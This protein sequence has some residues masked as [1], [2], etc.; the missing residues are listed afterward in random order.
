MADGFDFG[1]RFGQTPLDPGSLE[2]LGTRGGLPVQNL[3]PQPIPAMIGDLSSLI[4]G[5][6]E[7]N[8]LTGQSKKEIEVQTKEVSKSRSQQIQETLGFDPELAKELAESVTNIDALKKQEDGIKQLEDIFR[9][10]AEQPLQTDLSALASLVDAWTGSNF[11]KTVK[12]SET[13]KQRRNTLVTLANKIQDQKASLSTK[14]INAISAQ[15]LSKFKGIEE[16]NILRELTDNIVDPAKKVR[17]QRL[18]SQSWTTFG[19]DFKKSSKVNIEGLRAVSGFKASAQAN[20]TI[21]VETLKRQLLRMS[22]DTRPSDRDIAAFGGSKEFTTRIT[23]F[24]DAALK[25][26]GFAARNQA[27]VQQL[28]DALAQIAAGG[29]KKSIEGHSRNAS[30]LLPLGTSEAEAQEHLYNSVGMSPKEIVGIIK[31]GLLG[32]QGASVRA[33]QRRFPTPAQKAGPPKKRKIMTDA[34][35]KRLKELKKKFGR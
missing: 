3:A 20:T 6:E 31:N 21:A 12:P 28:A 9:L 35:R 29:L 25:G 22:G 8:I 17:T 11:A 34:Q 5:G 33:A 14:V 24:W 15:R 13:P 23:Q 26:K 19:N 1:V 10:T 27:E 4:G 30:R 2:L 18:L 7:E 32:V 16:Q